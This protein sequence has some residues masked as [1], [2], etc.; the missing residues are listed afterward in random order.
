MTKADDRLAKAIYMLFNI[1]T[2]MR[3]SILC[4]WSK[5]Q[6]T[7]ML[8]FNTI[9]VEFGAEPREMVLDFVSHQDLSIGFFLNYS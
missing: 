4:M 7:F 1:S 3:V 5:I 9:A 6:L 8:T 2:W